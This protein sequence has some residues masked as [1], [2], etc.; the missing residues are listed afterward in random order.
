M[1]IYSI[2]NNADGSVRNVI[3]LYTP[4]KV[5]SIPRTSMD[6]AGNRHIYKSGIQ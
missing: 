6:F 4:V 3:V 5:A 2:Y 1:W